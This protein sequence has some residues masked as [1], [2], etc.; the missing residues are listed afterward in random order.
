MCLDIRKTTI[1]VDGLKK[2]YKF[3]QI[4]DLHMLKMDERDSE[5]RRKGYK[6][7]AD[8][9]FTLNGV[10][11]Y[12]LLPTFL[13]V[14]KSENALPIFTGD[15]VDIPTESAYEVLDKYM[16]LPPDAMFILGNHDWS[17]MDYFHGIDRDTVTKD[18]YWSDE[19]RQKYYPRYQKFAQNGNLHYQAIECDEIIYAGFDNTENQLDQSQCDFLISLSKKQKPIIIFCHNPF[20]CD[21]L[22]Q[23]LVDRWGERGANSTVVN[24]KSS[25]MNEQTKNFYRAML[26]P[27][28]NVIAVVAG[29]VHIEHD[30]L[31]EGKIPQYC[32][33]GAYSG[34]ARLFTIKA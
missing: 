12:D 3:L 34:I 10:P 14:A 29:H 22:H 8:D 26:S 19:Y 20:Y 1:K 11:T 6:K 7:R 27:D 15:T 31:I 13:E 28:S 16:P 9:Y 17:F 32:G 18:D 25:P 2:E 24:G 33:A 30:D 21:T 4:S 5:A 23:P